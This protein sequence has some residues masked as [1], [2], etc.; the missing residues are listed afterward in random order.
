MRRHPLPVTAAPNA[1]LTGSRRWL[2]LEPERGAPPVAI[3]ALRHDS[4]NYTGTSLVPYL[5]ALYARSINETIDIAGECA[6]G[7]PSGRDAS[8][9]GC[10][11]RMRRLGVCPRVC[12]CVCGIC[13]TRS[14][15]RGR[16]RIGNTATGA[17][18][19][20][21]EPAVSKRTIQIGAN[22]TGAAAVTGVIADRTPGV[23]QMPRR[24]M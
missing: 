12:V 13:A 20:S 3:P 11:D 22:A 18:A 19:G 24:T 8:T 4:D 1:V 5:E 14:A 16:R 6:S 21:A 9:G 23:A 2:Q 17:V 15:H 7:A 10:A